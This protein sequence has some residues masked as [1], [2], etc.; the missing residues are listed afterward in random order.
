MDFLIGATAACGAVVFTNPFDVLKTRMQLQGE[1]KSRGQYAVFYKNIPHAAVSIA[2]AEGLRSLQKG[3]LPALGYQFIMNGTR[4]GLYKRILDSGIISHADG[5][6]TTVGCV[7]AGATCGM[8]A[9][10]TGS[11]FYLVKTQLQSQASSSIAVGYQHEHRGVISAF[12][13]IIRQEGVVGLW[14]GATTSLPRVGTGSA[15]QLFSFSKSKDWLH[16]L[17]VVERDS[18]QS[19]LVGAMLSGIVIVSC[20]CP[21]D[22]IATRLYNQGVDKHGKGVLYSGIV[23]CTLKMLKTEG[24]RGFYKG[25]SAIYFRIGPHSFLNLVFWDSLH[26]LYDQFK[27]TSS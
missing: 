9:G 4:F 27:K 11:P 6:V 19:T 12:S 21:F 7:A 24:V 10:F 13:T 20:M 26:R 2:K 5:S 18:W 14:R 25:W 8:I 3:L 15:A 16:S 22:V 1:L 17:E 23:D